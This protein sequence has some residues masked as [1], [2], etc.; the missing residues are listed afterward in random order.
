MAVL[1]INGG[2]PVIEK[3]NEKLF[4]WPIVTQEDIQAV[5]EVLEAGS[6]SG[7]DITKQFEKEYAAWNG[8]KYALGT[9]NG[10][11]ALLAAMW[12]CGVG[13]GDEVIAPALTYWATALPAISL[14]ASVNFTDIQPDTLGMDPEDIEHRIGPR[15]KAII[16]VNYAALPADWDPIMAIARKHNLYVIE[17]NSHAHGAIYK[18][19]MCG[20][21]A[22]ISAA[23]L[24]SGK[25]L[26]AGEAGMITTD[27]RVLYERCIAF[28]HYE[29]TG[30]PSNYNLVDAQVH[31]EDLLPFRGMPMGGVKHRMNQTCAAMGRVQLKYYPE[32]IAEIDKAM[33]YFC[34]GIEHIPGV[35]GLRTKFENSTQGGWYACKGSYNAEAMKGV[36]CAKFCEAVMAE[37]CTARPGGNMPMHLHK[38]F[39]DLD[40]FRQGKPTVLAFGQR[41][42]RQGAGTL[43]VTENTPDTIWSLPWFKHF[44]KAAIDLHIAAVE[45]VAANLDEL[46]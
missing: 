18:G 46:I 19:R 42:V 8:T 3:E 23:S 35:K 30:M 40:F 7:S 17:D 2:K 6:M 28:G 29:R 43:P 22:D 45:K 5:T 33:N 39:H 38:V 9:C 27:N 1:A 16:V 24:M 10:T 31:E 26:A 34:D 25:S 13:A 32:R 20:S 44:D 15:T 4:H 14:G 37:G 21:I 11:A 36:S 41:D 12:A